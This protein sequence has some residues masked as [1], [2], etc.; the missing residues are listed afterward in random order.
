MIPLVLILAA[1]AGFLFWKG[2]HPYVVTREQMQHA[3]ERV[4]D[5]KMPA[6]EWHRLRH[7]PIDRDRYLE[8]LRLRL[9]DLPLKRRLEDDGA[10]H[11]PAALATITTLLEE[12][13]RKRT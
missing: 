1:I 11:D 5:R 7:T 3:L 6:E 9:V 8:S 10:L 4:L 13:R 2:R 12:L